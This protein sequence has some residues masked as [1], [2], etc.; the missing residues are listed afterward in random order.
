MKKSLL[1]LLL[2]LSLAPAA[3]A[4]GV[5]V[6]GICYNLNASDLTAEVTNGGTTGRYEGAVTVPATFSHDGS[7]YRVTA[8]GEGAFERCSKLEAVTLPAT[9]KRIGSRAFMRTSIESI[10]LPEGL[11][12]VGDSAFYYLWSLASVTL[13]STLKTIGSYAFANCDGAEINLPASLESVGDYAFY[14][15]GAADLQLPPTLIAVGDYAFSQCYNSNFAIPASLRHIGEG[16]FAYNSATIELVLPEGVESVGR[17]AFMGFDKLTSLSLPASLTSIGE[18]A[19]AAC[20]VLPEIRVAAGNPAYVAR[21]GVLYNRDMTTLLAYPGGRPE[22]EFAVPAGVTRLA[23]R[24]FC[25]ADTLASI[26]LGKTLLEM[27]DYALSLCTALKSVNIPESITALG[28]GM[29][30]NCI[31]LEYAVLPASLRTIGANAFYGC[32]GMKN[33][34]CH[35]TTPPDA[36][37]DETGDGFGRVFFFDNVKLNVPAGS[38]DLYRAAAPWSNFTKVQSITTGIAPATT[39]PAASARYDL[40]GH[41]LAT[42]QKGVNIVRRA[43]GT[44]V[45]VLE[46]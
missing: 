31:A 14:Q 32:T 11:E 36:T 23:A 6:D 37:G 46:K 18:G 22:V 9:L 34:Y 17:E 44:S 5:L 16:A 27:G 12:T 42:P 29:L 25:G 30:S 19:F 20:Y 26:N 35:A 39:A 43:D 4:D 45:K 1:T 24:S 40:A 8:I 13:P 3:W 28:E 7:E 38:E 10:A 33:L 41:R 21:G 2:L 15:C